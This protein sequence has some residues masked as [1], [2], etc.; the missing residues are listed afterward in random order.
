MPNSID[1]EPELA[2][3]IGRLCG[4]W[5]LA[6]LAAV[7]LFQTLTGLEHHT[8]I[9]LFG[10]FRSNATQADVLETLV[11]TQSQVRDMKDELLS[12][13]AAYR[14]LAPKRNAY[15]HNAF[16]YRTTDAGQL[17]QIERN[18]RPTLAVEVYSAKDVS[19]EQIDELTSQIKSFSAALSKVGHYLAL[20]EYEA[21]LAS[22][23]GRP[24]DLPARR[25]EL[26]RLVA[27]AAQTID[28]YLR[29]TALPQ[30]PKRPKK[31]R[32]RRKGGGVT[33]D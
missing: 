6:E 25:Q 16:G 26:S 20:G 8:A 10:F 3:A 27:D 30:S 33:P 15:V 24:I 21:Q 19:V 1:N 2:A 17:Y 23:Q 5:S 32:E 11:H 7:R 31:D 28:R 12:L 18:K 13:I 4:H 22:E 29:P 9:T 14:R